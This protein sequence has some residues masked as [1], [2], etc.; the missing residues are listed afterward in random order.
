MPRH[1]TPAVLATLVVLGSLVLAGCSAAV[2]P[3]DSTRVLHVSN[4]IGSAALV[5]GANITDR[6]ASF[7][8]IVTACGGEVTANP[9]SN[10]LTFGEYEVSVLLDPSG[11]LDGA[12]ERANGNLAAVDT[13]TL[14]MPIYWSRSGLKIADLPQW[15]TITPDGVTMSG[16]GPAAGTAYPPC[17][18]FGPSPE[19][20][21]G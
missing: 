19:P 5:Q 11:A 4:R 1:R 17:D 16:Q 12:L 3:D 7:S 20:G 21:A 2:T 8:R 9:S 14:S 6:V 13:S 10:G 18:P 15:I